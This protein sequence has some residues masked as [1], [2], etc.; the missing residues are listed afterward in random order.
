MEKGLSFHDVFNSFLSKSSPTGSYQLR[1]FPNCYSWNKMCKTSLY[2]NV[3]PTISTKLSYVFNCFQCFIAFCSKKIHLNINS[4]NWKFVQM[5]HECPWRCY[6]SDNY[7]KCL[8]E[9]LRYV[10]VHK[11]FWECQWRCTGLQ[12]LLCMNKCKCVCIFSKQRPKQGPACILWS[13]KQQTEKKSLLSRWNLQ[14]F[15]W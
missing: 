14:I 8:I 2:S 10:C 4:L 5:A 6:M 11:H 13:N 15:I 3:T 9:K 1:S 7:T 12:Q